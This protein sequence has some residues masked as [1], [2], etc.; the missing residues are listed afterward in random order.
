MSEDISSAA[1]PAQDGVRSSFTRV[2]IRALG[3]TFLSVLSLSAAFYAFVFLPQV[4]DLFF[5]VR[6]QVWQGIVYWLEFYVLT[7]LVW[8]VPLAF[9]ARLLL[10]QNFEA[11]GV[12]SQW[13]YNR[14]VLGLP[15]FYLVLTCLLVFLGLL[16][17]VNNLPSPSPVT[18]GECPQGSSSQPILGLCAEQPLNKYLT[19]HLKI[20]L[21]ASIF[22]FLLLL[23]RNLF[24]QGYYNRIEKLENVREQFYH[25]FLLR[26]EYITKKHKTKIDDNS[27]YLFSLKPKWMSDDVWIS[28]Q[29]SKVFMCQYLIVFIIVVAVFILIHYLS[30]VEAVSKFFAQFSLF[31]SAQFSNIAD[32][33]W[34]KRASFIPIALGAWLPFASFLALLSNRFQVPIIVSIIAIGIGLSFFFSDGHDARLRTVPAEL[35]S[36]ALTDA[37][38]AWKLA[39]GC[40]STGNAPD[41]AA[42]AECPRPIIVSGEGGGSRAAYLIASTL[43]LLEDSS[44]SAARDK[45]T[46]RF[47]QQ[48]FGISAVS[49]SAVGSALFLGALRVH[50]QTKLE[51]LKTGIYAQ[52][53]YFLNIVNPNNDFLDKCVTYKDSLQAIISNDFISP[54]IAA[55]LARDLLTISRLP[56]VFDRAGVLERS[57]ED[58]F[59]S[60]YGRDIE[61]PLAAALKSFQSKNTSKGQAAPVTAASATAAPC[62][63]IAPAQG[64]VPL[65]FANATSGETGRRV[66]VSPV[67]WRDH[68][69]PA[70]NAFSDSYDFD[71]LICSDQAPRS[72]LDTISSYLPFKFSPA[73]QANCSLRGKMRDVDLRLSTAAGISSRSPFISPHATVRDQNGQAI[74]S[75]VD[76]GYF[77]N[78]GAVSAYEL[79]QAIRA[80]DPALKP[81]VMQVTSEPDWFADSK[82]CEDENRRYVARRQLGLP[83]VGAPQLPYQADLSVLGP[84]GDALTVNNTRIARGFETMIQMATRMEQLSGAN[85]FTEMYVCP[86]MKT[87]GIAALFGQSLLPAPRIGRQSTGIKKTS[88]L[89]GQLKQARQRADRQR[90][91]SWKQLSLSWWLSPPL[92]AYLDAQ[93]YAPHNAEALQAVIELLQVKTAAATPPPATATTPALP[94]PAP[95]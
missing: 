89:R 83:A 22:A 53:L 52:R 85:S 65:L 84:V 73:P 62:G 79:A 75:L 94:A 4:Q 81:F 57:W 44:I 92:Q 27:L 14:I 15:G 91:R 95:Q 70:K 29:R 90:I 87:S 64:W 1:A 9:T 69:D 80:I 55:F 88:E 38:K 63:A 16:A 32:A 58:A 49:G 93:V 28:S 40:G 54:A 31:S 24:V 18:V 10:L 26:F 20:L 8:A 23:I 50:D 30:Y 68:R 36:L 72:I 3:I 2:L 6:P 33:I 39:N 66:I 19:T 71:Q 46:R 47:S 77:D 45:P 13:R 74:D 37:I 67:D 51:A 25:K 21:G 56:H 61:N 76:G 82:N 34:T 35:P 7:I 43:G 42:P 12:D 11:I 17:A 48:L 59:S 78:S 86:Q 5:D 60:V 41:A